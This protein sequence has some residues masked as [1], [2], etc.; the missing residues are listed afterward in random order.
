MQTLT[1]MTLGALALGAAGLVYDTSTGQTAPQCPAREAAVYF[2]KGEPRFNEF[3]TAV[4][5]RVAAEARAC[6]AREVV[7]ET[8]IGGAYVEAITSAFDA[9]GLNVVVAQPAI[10]PDAGDFITGRA[11]SVRLTMHR[12]VGLASL[13]GN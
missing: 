8:S 10:V 7:A 2:E 4:I 12:D 3:S 9:K 6:G 1:A 13:P 5:E 11:A